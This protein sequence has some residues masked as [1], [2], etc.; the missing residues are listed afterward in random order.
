MKSIKSRDIFYLA[1]WLFIAS[2][3]LWIVRG[4]KYLAIITA[5]TFIYTLI[6]KP[7]LTIKNKNNWIVIIFFTFLFFQ[8]L[9]IIYSIGGRES[10]SLII[11]TLFLISF[12]FE[13]ITKSK[14]SIFL[15][16]FSL[17]GFL[18]TVNYQYINP[19]NRFYWPVN[20]IPAAT[21]IAIVACISFFLYLEKE[22]GKNR[23]VL[24]IALILSST[25]VLMS[26]SRGVILALGITF[27]IIGLVKLKGHYS[28][29]SKK[30]IIVTSSIIILISMLSYPLIKE[31]IIE[32]RSEI[33]S[34]ASNNLN[35]SIG[36]RLQGYKVAIDIFIENPI[37]GIGNPQPK[38]DE[39]YKEK[40]I[41]YGLHKVL[42][43]NFHNNFLNTMANQ[44]LV[45]LLFLLTLIFYPVYFSYMN[46]N[47]YSYAI[48]SISTLY[49]LA[50]LSDTPF[51]NGHSFVLYL[52]I[53]GTLISLSKKQ[54][55]DTR[56]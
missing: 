42:S 32:T 5:I 50:S 28:S 52:I 4:D 17:S 30:G 3:M 25:G 38:I 54:I 14:I 7:R 41:N 43:W 9:Q 15:F 8:S 27:I 31:R 29:I 49:F 16:I 18:F 39:L 55:E 26:E 36:Y 10:R 33:Q 51:T 34:I 20:A 6:K 12:P 37:F 19:T 23:L 40:I 56:S 47:Q 45:G 46:K 22:F 13:R 35:T 2:S 24:L 53:V 11:A 44:G 21:C 48:S 1:P